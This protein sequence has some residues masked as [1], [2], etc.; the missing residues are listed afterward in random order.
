MK[1]LSVADKNKHA[2]PHDELWVM[3]NLKKTTLT[4]PFPKVIL[5]SDNG[6]KQILAETNGIYTEYLRLQVNLPNDLTDMYS[7]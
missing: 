1:N 5:G 3:A 7:N 6:G 2:I 4:F